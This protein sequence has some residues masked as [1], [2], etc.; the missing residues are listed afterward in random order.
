MNIHQPTLLLV[1]DDLV[2]L[3]ILVEHLEEAG[4][5]T[6]SAMNGCEAWSLL[7]REPERFDAVLL[8]RM[9]PVMNGMEVLAK[10]KAHGEL[11]FLPVILQTAAG[12]TEEVRQGIEAGAFYY[13]TKPFTKEVV[14][15]IVRAAVRD[16]A[17]VKELHRE[18]GKQT[19]IFLCLDSAQFHFQ[20]LEEAHVL[21]LLLANACPDP[22]RVVPGLTELM[23]NAIE[24]GN[25]DITYEEKSRL[26]EEGILDSELS[27]R[28]AL[29]EFSQKKVKIN[30]R[31]T[32]EVIEFTITD[33]GTGFDWKHYMELSPDRGMA[34]HG[35]GIA[36]ARALSFD[37]IVY[38]GIGNQLVCVV[39]LSG[40]SCS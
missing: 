22:I 2:N 9:M 25:L 36:L 8:D 39:A 7:E 40:S 21:A 28:L 14:L 12:S 38:Q 18:L 5:Q 1:D 16:Y 6:V 20:T 10:I 23:I 26:Q 13:L 33:Q 34:T 30:F 4:Y 17:K 11:D 24:H 15:A 37:S 29:P 27:R 3:E 31:R 19:R 32:Q 35:R